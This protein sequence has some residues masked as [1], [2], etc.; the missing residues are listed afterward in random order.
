MVRRYKIMY[1]EE[2]PT[3][4]ENDCLLFSQESWDVGEERMKLHNNP[5]KYLSSGC[6]NI[7]MSFQAGGQWVDVKVKEI[8]VSLNKEISTGSVSLWLQ[9]VR[10]A[11]TDCF[12]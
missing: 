4:S 7:L 11:A 12:R 1:C 10:W 8:L 5:Y 2:E 9:P 6:R 3:A